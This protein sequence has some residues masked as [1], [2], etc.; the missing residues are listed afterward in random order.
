M[1]IKPTG[2]AAIAIILSKQVCRQ[3]FALF[4]AKNALSKILPATFLNAGALLIS[5][6]AYRYQ[7]E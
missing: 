1:G 4:A 6:L 2:N 3:R 5:I 7:K